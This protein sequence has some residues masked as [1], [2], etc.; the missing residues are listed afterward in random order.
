M[1]GFECR[2][3]RASRLAEYLPIMFDE[4]QGCMVKATY[5]ATVLEFRFLREVGDRKDSYK[6]FWQY[7]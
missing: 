2:V 3:K 6:D 1:G 5:H 4:Y 7:L